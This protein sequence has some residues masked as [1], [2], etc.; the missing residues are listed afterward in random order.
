MK[1]LWSNN[2]WKLFS[3]VHFLTYTWIHESA[4]CVTDFLLQTWDIKSRFGE[5]FAMVHEL[6]LSDEWAWWASNLHGDNN[7]WGITECWLYLAQHIRSIECHGKTRVGVRCVLSL[8]MHS[9]EF[10]IMSRGKRNL[11]FAKNCGANSWKIVQSR[12]KLREWAHLQLAGFLLLSLL[13]PIPPK[14]LYKKDI[15]SWRWTSELVHLDCISFLHANKR[16]LVDAGRPWSCTAN[17]IAYKFPIKMQ[18]SGSSARVTD[19]RLTTTSCL[20]FPCPV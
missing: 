9:P 15:R 4:K 20:H 8:D 19:C 1:I 12:L 2:L 16:L 14:V 18:S 3:Q 6:C 7:K 17:G 11:G 10:K 5:K 13:P